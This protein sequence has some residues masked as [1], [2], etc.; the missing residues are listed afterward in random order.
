MFELLYMLH[1]S[2]WQMERCHRGHEELQRHACERHRC[3]LQL[4]ERSMLCVVYATPFL[5]LEKALRER[6]G[7]RSEC[8][9]PALA[10][11]KD[12]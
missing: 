2:A 9:I 4:T 10:P 3:H 7:H 5:T 12:T 1:M 11:A 6:I 8:S